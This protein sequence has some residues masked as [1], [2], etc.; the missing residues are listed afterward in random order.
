M[1]SYQLLF[2]SKVTTVSLMSVIAKHKESLK[3]S[4]KTDSLKWEDTTVSDKEQVHSI[5]YDNSW[6]LN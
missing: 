6:I 2:A 4:L 5:V 1:Q 3:Q